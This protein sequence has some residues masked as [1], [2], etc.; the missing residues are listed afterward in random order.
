MSAPFWL[1]FGVTWAFLKWLYPI[2]IV[3]CRAI[4]TLRLIVRQAHLVPEL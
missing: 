2:G 1:D 3:S 4:C